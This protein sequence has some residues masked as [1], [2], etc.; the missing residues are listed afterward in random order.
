MKRIFEYIKN[1]LWM[2]AL[3]VITFGSILTSA[4]IFKQSPLHILPMF[5]SLVVLFLQSKV[6]RYAFL[7]GAANSCLYGVAYIYRTLYSSAASAILLSFPIQVLT[8]INWN[9]RTE[10]QSG[11]KV[12][13]LKLMSGKMRLAL[14]GA[15]ALGWGLLYVIFASLGS[16]Y[17]L[18]DNTVTILGIVTMVLCALCYIEYAPL[19]LAGNLVS[20]VL[21][22]TMIPDSAENIAWLINSIYASIC[23]AAAYYAMMK[24]NR[25]MKAEK[26]QSETIHTEEISL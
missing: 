6:N 5:I 7:L 4:I 22:I 1:N 21:N 18:L 17:I 20:V 16:P 24:Q 13:E 2:T 9:R 12:T 14:G 3:Q 19:Q 8:F 23:T 15:T 11:S 25:A 26:A 10:K